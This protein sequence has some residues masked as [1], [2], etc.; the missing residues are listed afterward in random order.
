MKRFVTAAVLMVGMAGLVLAG[1]IVVPGDDT[2]FT[3]QK[4]DTVRI[5]VPGIAGTIVKAT[6]NGPAK[7]TVNRVIRLKN[8]KPLIGPGNHEVEVKPTGTGKVTV[9]ISVKSPTA[10]EE[11]SKYEFEVK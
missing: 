4:D 11:K 3:V 7:G 1:N 10:E 8:G 6:V 2:P 9:E 5:P